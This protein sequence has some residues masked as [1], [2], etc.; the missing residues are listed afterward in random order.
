MSKRNSSKY[1]I[2]RRKWAENIWGR[3]KSP[4]N[5]RDYGRAS[6]GQR[7]KGKC[8]I[9]YATACQAEAEKVYY[10]NI[11]ES[12]SVAIYQKRHECAGIH[13]KR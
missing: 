8:L 3:P 6:M 2:D 10:G 7:R 13:R 5:R 1:K 11:T 9:R 4:V 12:N